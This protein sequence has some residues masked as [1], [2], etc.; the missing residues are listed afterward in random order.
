MKINWS[1]K[2]TNQEVLQGTGEMKACKQY[3]KRKS[4]LHWRYS[5]LLHDVIEEKITRE[6]SRKEKNADH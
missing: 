6:R 5:S 2:V 4:Q 1:E 3:S